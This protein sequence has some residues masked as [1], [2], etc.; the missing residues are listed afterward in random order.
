MKKFSF[1]A[2]LLALSF[3]LC[4]CLLP[5]GLP[6]G[7][8]SRMEQDIL[9]F[10]DKFEQDFSE[11]FDDF[12]SK[13]FN[14]GL[15]ESEASTALSFPEESEN[16]S[17]Y[18]PSEPEKEIPKIPTLTALR[19]YLCSQKERGNFELEFI[20]TGDP[21]EVNGETIARITSACCITWWCDNGNEY[22]IIIYEYPGDKI[23]DAYFGGNTESLNYDERKTLA[24]AEKILE[25]ARSE[26]DSDFELEL[27]LHDAIAERVT[28]YA[29]PT[30]VPDPESP[31]RHLTAVGA[32]LDKKANCQGY[33]DAFYLL[34]TMAGFRVNRMN[35][36][37]EDGWHIV[38]TVLLDNAWYIVDV[39]FD[40]S[41]VYTDGVQPS[42]RLFNAG[43]DVCAEY[44]WGDEMEYYPIKNESD[45]NYFYFNDAE[46]TEFDYEKAYTDI[47]LLAET[48]ILDHLNGG[49][50]EYQTLLLNRSFD[51]SVLD[52]AMQK[53]DTNGKPFT[54][55]IW[56]FENGKDTFYL[57]RFE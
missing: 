1:I 38:N 24:E 8:E 21:N 5:F 46:S 31:P 7:I 48:I 6:E 54:Y 16:E 13:S 50:N 52:E 28:Y 40:D 4:G 47:D 34:A 23:A 27:L 55:T 57:V 37:N 22:E 32:L 14:E 33:A 15:D 12:Y 17:E 19:D 18:L 56:A 26:A 35:V 43:R 29:G 11:A 45:E 3:V 36:Y 30:E 41:V 49:G 44:A 51:W 42:Y 20:Y 9:S 25:Q 10:A 53:V 39:T 2:L